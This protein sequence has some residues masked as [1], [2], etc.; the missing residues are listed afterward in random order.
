MLPMRTVSVVNR[1]LWESHE[2]QMKLSDFYEIV[3][4][5]TVEL[6]DECAAEVTEALHR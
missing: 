1:F 5:A 4:V 3:S 2:N 6:T